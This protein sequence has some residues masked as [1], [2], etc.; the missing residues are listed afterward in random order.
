MVEKIKFLFCDNKMPSRKLVGHGAEEQNVA[1]S[2]FKHCSNNSHASQK[3]LKGG[4]N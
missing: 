4:A 1:R 2:D 3:Y